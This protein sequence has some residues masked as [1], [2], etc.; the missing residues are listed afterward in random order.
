MYSIDENIKFIKSQ[1]T[2]TENIIKRHPEDRNADRN[3]RPI[4]S[5]F[6]STIEHLSRVT[7]LEFKLAES[8]QE[9]R[10]L[11]K[12]LMLKEDAY[13]SFSLTSSE[14]SRVPDEMKPHLSVSTADELELQLL[15][16][17]KKK[18]GALSLD[19]VI[20]YYYDDTGE[21]V[22]RTRMNQRLY[23]LVQK[24]AFA[25]ESRGILPYIY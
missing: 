4:I 23:R 15:E 5:K 11:R 16:I 17:F 3:L 22:E 21:V 14:M 18:G 9:L 19:Q 24:Q 13:Q 12:Q 1:Q 7:D 6:E 8:N 20:L 2:R 25:K 10:H